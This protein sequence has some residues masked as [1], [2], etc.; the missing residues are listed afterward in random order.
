[1]NLKGYVSVRLPVPVSVQN[2]VLRDY[3]QR[4]GH[5][6]F[7]ADVE[8]IMP[9]CSIM[10]Q[11]L[12]AQPFLTGIVAYSMFMAPKELWLSFAGRDVHFAL[13]NYVWPRDEEAC[14]VAWA[15]KEAA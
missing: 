7:L 1:M 8:Y 15:L 11:G 9:G 10:L 5:T 3:C 14:K 13:E 12:A 6:Y 2:L 4:N